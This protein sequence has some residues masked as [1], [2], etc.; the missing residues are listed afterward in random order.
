M[1]PDR[2]GV[3]M[4]GEYGNFSPSLEYI[5]VSAQNRTSNSVSAKY[6]SECPYHNDENRLCP[7]YINEDATDG[8]HLLNLGLDYHRNIGNSDTTWSIRLNN[9]LNEKIYVHNSFLPFV[10]QQG[11]NISLSVSTK[12]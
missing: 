1:S 4:S 5:R 7:I 2:I 3:R 11:R 8:Y 6:N 12:F 10:P 9:A